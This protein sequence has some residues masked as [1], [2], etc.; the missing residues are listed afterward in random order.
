VPAA[1]SPGCGR[2]RRGRR[3]GGPRGAAGCACSTASA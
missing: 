3:G 1:R 2:A